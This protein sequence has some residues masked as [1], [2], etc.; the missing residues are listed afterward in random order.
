MPCLPKGM[1]THETYQDENDNYVYPHQVMKNDQ[2][3]VVHVDTGKPIKV[4]PT[5][6]I[7]KSKNNGVDPQEMFDTY[8]ADAIR[9]FI[10][11][12]SPPERDMPWTAGG[13]DGAWRF[14][15]KLHREL[16][17]ID[18]SAKPEK[19]STF[20]EN[21]VEL[22]R[23]THAAMKG[24]AQDIE[25]FHMNKAVARIREFS[26]ALFAFK[27]KTEDEIWAQ[28]EGAKT[29][30]QLI[31]PMTPHLAEELWSLMGHT[32]LLADEKWPVA[33]ESLLVQ[34][35]VTMAVQVN[36]KVRATITMQA[37]ASRKKL[38]PSPWLSRMSLK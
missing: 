3:D 32:T 36:G 20:S 35:T 14:V 31:N 9:F 18:L 2:G 6:K 23:A 13:V 29:L 33:D 30:I 34:D 5:I 11:S 27:P 10:L 22:R 4:G 15:N 21:A 37:D 7:S 24:V 19:P 16:S 17:N 38:K 8:G 26:N 25:D 1:L 28:Y 12:D